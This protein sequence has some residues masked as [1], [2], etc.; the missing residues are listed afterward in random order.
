[1]HKAE[2]QPGLGLSLLA[3]ASYYSALYFEKIDYDTHDLE[4]HRLAELVSLM[5][6]QLL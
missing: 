1:M 4:M 2:V 5:V 6:L 3:Q